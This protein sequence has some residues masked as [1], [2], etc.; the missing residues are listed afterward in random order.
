MSWRGPPCP[1]AWPAKALATPPGP[2][3]PIKLPRR[4]GSR[5]RSRQSRLTLAPLGDHGGHPA[6]LVD[7]EIAKHDGRLALENA[8]HVQTDPSDL[9]VG[10]RMA[11]HLEHMAP[12]PEVGRKDDFGHRAAG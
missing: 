5:R 1:G 8:Q 2:R 11:S 7:L 9:P 12:L 4:S 6:L 3:G 10:A